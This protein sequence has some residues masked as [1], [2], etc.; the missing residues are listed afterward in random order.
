MPGVVRSEVARSVV[1]E[2]GRGALRRS[3]R[4]PA[5]KYD[6]TTVWLVVA[7]VC[8]IDLRGSGDHICE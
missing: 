6:R 4:V 2:V 8:F 7:L 5:T 1:S 3:S